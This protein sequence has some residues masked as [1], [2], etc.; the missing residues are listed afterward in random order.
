M[1]NKKR[2]RNGYRKRLGRYHLTRKNLF[3][4]EKILWAYADVREMEKAGVSKLPDGRKHMPRKYVDRHVSIGRYRPFYIELFRGG[5][6]IN[7]PGV[8]WIYQ[9]DSVKL[10]TSKKGYP[11]APRYFKLDAW[12]GI[13]VTLRP[14]STEIF[15]QTHYATGAELR[16]MK[17]AIG[18][19]EKYLRALQSHSLN[20]TV[21]DER[22]NKQ[23]R[24]A[25]SSNGS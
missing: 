1:A 11:R 23:L 19:I 17:K 15:A 18:A 5:Y 6:G 13:S 7:Y 2:D 4:L 16:A 22:Y 21:L 9:E 12:P 10:L 20:R 25:K 3:D 14:F 8:D 24:E